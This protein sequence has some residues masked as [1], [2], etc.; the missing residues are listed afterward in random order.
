MIYALILL[1]L[2]AISIYLIGK[3][4]GIA[5]PDVKKCY[6][7]RTDSIATLLDRT[8]WANHHL[9]RVNF[10][11]RFLLFAIVISFFASVV[12]ERSLN[13]QN[14]L[15]CTIIIWILLLGMSNFFR[16]HADQ[17]PDYFIDGNLKQIRMKQKLPENIGELQTHNK[18]FGGHSDCFRHY[19]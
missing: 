18:T 9:D 17:F 1:I 15:V 3:R 16:F 19:G 14:M 2:L 7:N 8:Q 10:Q 5:Q 11:A 4:L 13:A 12:Y 6:G